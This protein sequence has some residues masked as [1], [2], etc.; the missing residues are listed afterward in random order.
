[1]A[2]VSTASDRP[3]I[4]P[5]ATTSVTL[6]VP[7][8]PCVV[9]AGVFDAWSWCTSSVLEWRRPIDS[10]SL[11]VDP[12]PLD[13]RN[14]PHLAFVLRKECSFLPCELARLHVYGY[15]LSD[16]LTLAPYAI[17]D[18]TDL[19]YEHR[20]EPHGI[21]WLAASTLE[22]L[23]WGLH[24]WSHFHH[25]GPFDQ[26]AMT[27][28][29]CDLLALH[30]LRRNAARIGV[31]ARRLD[32]VARDLAS[33]SRRRFEEEGR[34]PPTD[35]FEALFLGSYPSSPLSAGQTRDER[36]HGERQ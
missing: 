1:M 23:I 13:G 28:L 20:V 27:E 24:D 11:D 15:G 12:R 18:A 32:T 7:P 19:L 29:Q 8:M 6:D 10:P 22:S 36:V 17:D 34:P 2:E 26:P 33:L 30:W 31:G 35:D 9:P 4:R 14:P 25:H 21:F 16:E 5:L 3:Q